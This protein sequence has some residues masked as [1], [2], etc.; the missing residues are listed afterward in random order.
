MSRVC[1][2]EG[3]TLVKESGQWSLQSLK[4]KDYHNL[5]YYSVRTNSSVIGQSSVVVESNPFDDP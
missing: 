1:R 2:N 3:F 5:T 4:V